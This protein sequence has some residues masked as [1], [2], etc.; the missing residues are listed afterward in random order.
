MGLALGRSILEAH[1]GRIWMETPSDGGPG[2]VVCFSIPLSG[3]KR[4]RRG[5][6]VC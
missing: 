1:H 6:I 4:K 2:T 5:S 3:P